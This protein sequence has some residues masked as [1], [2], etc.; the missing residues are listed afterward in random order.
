M[1]LSDSYTYVRGQILLMDPIPAISKTFSLV[2][3]EE[4]QRSIVA[5]PPLSNVAA[6]HG[7]WGSKLKQGHPISEDPKLQ[8]GVTHMRALRLGSPSLNFNLSGLVLE[9]DDWSG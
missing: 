8:E 2:L 3:Q 7:A 1:G 9:D 5:P 6:P 4:R